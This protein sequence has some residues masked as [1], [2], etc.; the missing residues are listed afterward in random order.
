M[1]NGDGTFDV[2]NHS[3]AEQVTFGDLKPN[4]PFYMVNP[5]GNLSTPPHYTCEALDADTPVWTVYSRW[6]FNRGA[7][8]WVKP[9]PRRG[10]LRQVG[11]ALFSG[12]DHYLCK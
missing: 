8:P 6:E 4:A 1:L 11:A 2:R 5:L 10:D 7:N 9:L 3:V 12:L